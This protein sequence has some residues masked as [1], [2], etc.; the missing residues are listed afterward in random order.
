MISVEEETNRLVDDAFAKICDRLNDSSVQVRAEAARLLVRKCI[1]TNIRCI[2]M[3]FYHCFMSCYVMLCYFRKSLQQG[4]VKNVSAEFLLQTLDKKL[5]SNMRV[6][7]YHPVKPS[8][9]HPRVTMFYLIVA[10]ESGTRAA[11]GQL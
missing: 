7:C 9:F 6:S 5:M 2:I 11:E 1:K 10:K 4:L 3:L 8:N